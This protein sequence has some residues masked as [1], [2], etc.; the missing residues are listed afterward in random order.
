MPVLRRRADGHLCLGDKLIK[1]VF[2]V[3]TTFFIVAGV[4]VHDSAGLAFILA[5]VVCTPPRH[6]PV[7][8]ADRQPVNLLNVEIPTVYAGGV[9]NGGMVAEQ[10]LQITIAGANKFSRPV[11]NSLASSLKF[12]GSNLL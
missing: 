5:N 2:N 6:S 12:H 3:C 9:C 1:Q 8:G 4:F 11:D 10:G 7:A